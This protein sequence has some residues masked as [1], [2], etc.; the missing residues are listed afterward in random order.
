MQKLNKG[1]FFHAKSQIYD[2]KFHVPSFPRR[3]QNYP[4]LL[5]LTSTY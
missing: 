1:R 3:T 4:L 5:L 2:K